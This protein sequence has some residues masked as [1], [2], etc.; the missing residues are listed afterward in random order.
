MEEEALKDYKKMQDDLNHV[1]DES[2]RKLSESIS[3]HSL[4][5]KRKGIEYLKN[6]LTGLKPEVLLD[7]IYIGLFGS[8]G[9]GKSTLLNTIIDKNYFLPVSGNKACT[10]CVVQVN[11]SHSKQHEAKIHLLTDEEWKDELKDLVALA[12]PDEDEDSTERKEALLKICT[13]YGTKAESKTYE[14]LC[15]MKPIVQI[16]NSRCITLRETKGEDLS[17]KMSPYIR[18]QSIHSG[19]RAE[20]SNEDQRTRLWPLVKNVEVTIPSLQVLPAGVVFVDIP[21]MGDFN[22]KRDAMWKKNINRCSV[23]W[24][25][26]SIERIQGSSTHEMLLKEGTKAFQCGMC[27]DM[28]LVVTKS[29]QMNLNEYQRSRGL[30]PAEIIQMCNFCS[31]NEHDAILERNETVKQDKKEMMKNNLKKKLPSNSEVLHKADLVYTVSAWEYWNGKVLNKEETEI[32]KLRKYIQTFYAAQKRNKLKDHATEAFVIFSLIQSLQSNQDAQHQHVK[33][34]CLKALVKQKIIDLEKGIKECFQPIEQPL[35]EGVEQAKQLYKENIQKILFREHGY[36]GFHRTLK[37]VCLKNGVYVSRI[38][39]RIDI[40]ESLAQPIY[41]KID[42]CFG[43]VFRIQMGNSSTLKACLDSFKDTMQQQLQQA[44]AEYPTA[45]I[46]CKLKFLQQ[47]KTEFIIREAEKFILQKK[48]E[49]YHSLTTSFE[50]D[51][52]PY[53]EDAARQGGFQAS[54]RMQTILSDGVKSEVEKGMFE[55]AQENMRYHFQELKVEIIRKMETDFSDMLSLV[56]CTW[57]QRNSK[58][59]GLQN[60]FLFIRSIQQKL[61]SAGDA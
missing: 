40:N 3:E 37:A 11:T 10:S 51:L 50:K 12:S 56:F 9:A 8:T 21:G 18:I 5:E 34:S 22:S 20:T 43:D 48:G 24:V 52:L 1:L 57:D 26:S 54:K 25:I 30:L 41:E 19:A 35:K 45:D 60:E 14:E 36:Q 27:R 55:K 17:E 7:P 42:L 33:A 2:T 53:Y 59:P 28:S 29:D 44:L 61:H 46:E 39:L 16:P 38:F 4:S 31:I 6:R 15:R 47:K 32:P 58:L 49:I 23:I 13:I